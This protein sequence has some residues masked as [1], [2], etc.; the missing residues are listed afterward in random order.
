MGRHDN[1][2]CPE[3]GAELDDLV[4]N[5]RGHKTSAGYQCPDCDTEWT[6]TEWEGGEHS[7]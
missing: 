6:W 1:P 3:C 2:D 5:V 4:D 7:G